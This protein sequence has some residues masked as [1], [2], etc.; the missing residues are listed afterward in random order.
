MSEVKC[1]YSLNPPTSSTS[2]SK[3]VCPAVAGLMDIYFRRYM[4]DKVKKRFNR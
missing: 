3:I 1:F 2:K 4:V